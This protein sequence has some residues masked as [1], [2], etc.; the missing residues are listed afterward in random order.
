MDE[1]LA[2]TSKEI[3]H[4]LRKLQQGLAHHHSHRPVEGADKPCGRRRRRRRRLG[5]RTAR[6]LVWLLLALRRLDHHGIRRLHRL[7]PPLEDL[8]RQARGEAA[9]AR[10]SAWFGLGGLQFGPR[11]ASGLS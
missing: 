8:R 9:S 6:A 5:A 10:A 3:P 7:R 4:T 11:K 2:K 1:D